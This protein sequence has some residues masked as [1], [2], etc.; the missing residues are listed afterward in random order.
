MKIRAA[1]FRDLARIEELYLDSRKG[2]TSGAD[3][4]HGHPVPQATLLRLWYAVSKTVSA[5]MPLSEP[6]DALY[7][8]ESPQEGIVGFVQAEAAPVKPKAWQVLNLCVAP[9]ASGHFARTELLQELCNL[10]LTHGVHRFL[11]RLPLD[12]PL[13]P[14]F[15]E[16]GFIQFATEQILYSDEIP[17][18]APSDGS[19]RAAKREDIG[20]IYSLYLRTTPSH[21]ASLEGPSLK[22]WQSA[23]A[24]GALARIGKDDYPQFVAEAPHIVAWAGVRPA[25]GTRPTVLSVMCEG[26]DATMREQFIDAVLQELSPGPVSSVLRHYDS[27][28]IRSLQTRGFDIYGSQLL[29]VRDLPI[30]VKLKATQKQ[31]TPLLIQAGIAQTVAVERH[32]HLRVVNRRDQRSSQI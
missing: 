32:S 16:Q 4:D 20:Q 9:T 28:L 24:Q 11:V 17:Q 13:L 30:K 22:M 2:E 8:A 21:V 10:G 5:L 27:E 26:H 29:L 31:K 12:H 14:V 1:S 6:G 15:I 19:I 3:L 18:S 25:T 7:V 23:F